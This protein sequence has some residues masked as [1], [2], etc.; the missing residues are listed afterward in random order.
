MYF[1]SF[2]FGH[3]EM[4]AELAARTAQT[5][6]RDA[7]KNAGEAERYA[8]DARAHVQEKAPAL[9]KFDVTSFLNQGM[10]FGC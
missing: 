10:H 2:A 3:K 9:G 5:E 4:Q 6:S 7:K 1:S 8:R